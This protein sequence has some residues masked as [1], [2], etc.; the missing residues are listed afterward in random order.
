[1][2]ETPGGF[3]AASK[4]RLDGSLFLLRLAVGGQALY[5]GFEILR[6]HHT[7]PSLSNAAGLGMALLDVIAGALVLVGLWTSLLATV[8]AALLAWPL[9]AGWAHGSG[10]LFHPAWMAR[11][12]TT[13]ACAIGGGGKWALDR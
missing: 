4:S 11:L 3:L 2:E 1:M 12:L 13:L 10:L 5:Q 8:L 7:V 6:H 9:V